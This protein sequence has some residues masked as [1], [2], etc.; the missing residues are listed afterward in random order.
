MPGIEPGSSR[1]PPSLANTN[2][3]CLASRSSSTFAGLTGAH[4]VYVNG[5]EIGSGGQFPPD[6]EDGRDGNHRHKIPSGSFS[7]PISGTN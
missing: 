7:C 5:K 4:E 2:V 6:F 3:I 1:T